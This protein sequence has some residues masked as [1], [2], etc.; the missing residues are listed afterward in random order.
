M[1]FAEAAGILEGI[2]HISRHSAQI[3]YDFVLTAR[4]ANCLELGFAHGASSGYIC[5]ALDELGAGN[6]T[7]VDI[8]GSRNFEPAIE[9]TLARLGLT[10][11]VDVRREQNS[12]NWFL[13]KQIESQ[14]SD[15]HCTPCYDF[16]FIDGSKN[17][18]IDG[19]AF[20]LADKLLREGGW[21]LF[22]DYEWRYADAVERG[23]QATDGVSIRELSDDQIDQ[24]NVK[25]IFELLVAQHPHYSNCQVQDRSWAWA[26]KVAGPK[27]II[28]TRK[29]R[30]ASRL[31]RWK[32]SLG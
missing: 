31:A 15:G 26:Q 6:L 11:Y 18:T 23:K 29:S 19:L 28:H 25:A 10:Q 8:D 21:I 1:K 20:Y 9:D 24:P 2:P 32:S 12:Y 22:D 14:T 4:P 13:K 3:L 27:E 17:W 5:A 16:V 30:L 7:S